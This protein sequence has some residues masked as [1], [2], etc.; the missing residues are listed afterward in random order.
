VAILV[1]KQEI[2]DKL[3]KYSMADALRFYHAVL[4]PIK[5][6]TDKYWQV[7][8]QLAKA[9]RFFLLTHLLHRPDAIHPWLYARCRELENSPDGH[10]DLWS[11]FHYKDIHLSVRIPTPTGAKLFGDIHPGDEVFNREGI[12]VKIVAETKIY[13]DS[14]CYEILFDNGEK[15]K[16]GAG[17]LWFV[18][19]NS[20]KRI[21]GT[22]KRVGWVEEVWETNQIV[23]YEEN[24]KLKP[25]WSPLKISFTKPVNPPEKDLIV[26]PYTLGAW[27]GDGSSDGGRVCC[28]DGG[29]FTRIEEE[30]YT[31]GKSVDRKEKD[32]FS[33][34]VLGVVTQL[35]TLNV[36]KNK[37][38]P[39]EYFTASKAQRLELLRGIFDTDGFYH[40]EDS[41]C[42]LTSARE[43]LAE[44]VKRLAASLGFKVFL[45]HYINDYKGEPYDV[46]TV[47]FICN[48]TTEI[49][50][51]IKRHLK[52][53]NPAGK[54]QQNFH[55]IREVNLIP[56]EPTKCIQVEG[57]GSFLCSDSYIPTH[58]ST[59]GTY[60][61]AIQEII[62]NPEITIC[63]L[64]YNNS[65]AT[66]FLSQLKTELTKNEDLKSAFPEIFY[67]NPERD[68]ESWSLDKGITVQRK[69]NPK[70]ATIE[71]FGLVD[72]QPVGRHYQLRIYDDVVTMNSVTTADMTQKTDEAWA[73]SLS[74]GAGVHG[75]RM[76][77]FGT[78]YNAADTYQTI[79]DREFLSP[80]I[81]PATDD[82]TLTGK[83]VFMDKKEWDNLVKGSSEY[84]LACQQLQNPLA[85]KNQEFDLDWIRRY[86]TRPEILNLYIVVDPAGEGNK[87]GGAACN[88]AMAVIGM[89]SQHNKYLLDGA[90][91][92]MTLDDRWKMLSKLFFKW[93]NS[94][95][96]QSVV[97]GY[98]RYSMQADIPHFKLQMK[99]EKKYFPI[100]EVAGSTAKNDRI[101]RL[102]PDFKN[103]AFFFPEVKVFTKRMKRYEETGR[104]HLV[105]RPIKRK[106]HNK[107]I[108]E[109]SQWVIDNEYKLFPHNKLKDF[110][111]AM[112][113]I[114]DLDM[115]PPM[116]MSHV[117]LEVEDEFDGMGGPSYYQGQSMEPEFV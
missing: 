117:Q 69:T 61:G 109:L 43:R 66:A 68:A 86:E 63:I 94:P 110:L 35:K 44:D 29:V 24:R 22:N 71:A 58:N 111:D 115:T 81:Y 65:T 101:R 113:R 20:K 102:I 10:L 45:N 21:P 57:D 37:H 54:Y 33:F 59:L 39:E 40:K 79:L 76:W 72:N 16:C 30:G 80:R 92:Q 1:I 52:R 3:Q 26:A 100:T 87:K 103:W 74:L 93:R 97:V 8:A 50:F 32:C 31:L 99:L 2:L 13:D 90:C 104:K 107:N 85:G 82:G 78:R 41:M 60:A 15:I 34:T 51:T 4:S 56:T 105:A 27:L 67:D 108:Y 18:N 64:S 98:E 49:P 83:L 95:G 77:H 25:S 38:I 114:Y 91:H 12:P 70:E 96:I 112:A 23:A 9:D 7:T 106:D 73:L 53:I 46:W 42:V 17:H 19:H 47:K 62:R 48:Q 55:Y 75:N 116:D 89:D 84:V 14:V 6:D 88:T 36:V 11:R 28:G 5:K